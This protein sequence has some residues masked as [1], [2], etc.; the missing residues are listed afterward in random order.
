MVVSGTEVPPLLGTWDGEMPELVNE[1]LNSTLLCLQ[2][3]V[4]AITRLHMREGSLYQG[5]SSVCMRTYHKE[6]WLVERMCV[7]LQY[8]QLTS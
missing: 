5:Y 6:L 8:L 1:V 4:I 2:P 3:Q 7:V